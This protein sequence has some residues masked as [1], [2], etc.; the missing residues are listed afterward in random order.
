MIVMIIL[1]YIIHFII[2]II[3]VD[4]TRYEGNN[5]YL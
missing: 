4:G 2:P 5:I 3:I 1:C